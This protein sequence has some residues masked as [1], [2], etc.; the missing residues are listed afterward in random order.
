MKPVHALV[1]AG[2]RGPEDSVAV[3]A[4]VSHKAFADV[5][6]AP[7]L[8][9]VVRALRAAELVDGITIASERPDLIEA[10]P[11]FRGIRV[12]PTAAG[13]SGTVQAAFRQLGAPLLVTTADHALLQ[14]EW[15]DHFLSKLP[16]DADV[17]AAVA[18]SEDVEAAAPGVRRTYLKFADGAVSGCNLFYLGAPTAE[19]AVRFW[20]RLEAER[21][22]PWRMAMMIG[23][24]VLVDYLARRLTL[25]A[26]LD[27]LGRRA[28]VRAGVVVLPFGQAAIDVDKPDDLAL[29][30]R[31]A[32]PEP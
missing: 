3:A 1:L 6:G 11:E 31:L 12:L 15:V 21:K 32:R 5:G 26:A 17:S 16:T 9:R 25:D 28:G 23:P 2:S 19:G 27:L 29:A 10:V 14:P 8:L 13:P 22:R 20:T 4:G 7:M 30:R 18:R 24:G